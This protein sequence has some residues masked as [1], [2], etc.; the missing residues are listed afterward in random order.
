MVTKNLYIVPISKCPTHLLLDS[1]HLFL[2]PFT[3]KVCCPPLCGNPADFMNIGLQVYLA[4]SG[5]IRRTMIAL[6][7]DLSVKSTKLVINTPPSI[8]LTSDLGKR[9][10][11]RD[12]SFRLL[13]IVTGISRVSGKVNEWEMYAKFPL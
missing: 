13:Q 2:K 8:P 6:Y 4:S 3:F 5:I 12:K 9:R 1:L 7:S 10:M 11:S